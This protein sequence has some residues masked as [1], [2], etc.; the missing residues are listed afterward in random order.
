[1]VKCLG[2]SQTTIDFNQFFLEYKKSTPNKI[3]KDLSPYQKFQPVP[4]PIFTRKT[5]RANAA[6][7]MPCFIHWQESPCHFQE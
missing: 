6:M 4:A 7:R 1:M 5:D 2:L 3:T